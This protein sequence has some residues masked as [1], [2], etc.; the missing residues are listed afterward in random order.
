VSGRT[1]R[2]GQST[3]P[4]ALVRQREARPQRNATIG[5]GTDR[6]ELMRCDQPPSV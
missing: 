3:R 1:D 6:K 2:R 4:P 5:N